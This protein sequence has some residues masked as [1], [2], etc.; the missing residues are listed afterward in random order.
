MA[1]HKT[2]KYHKFNVSKEG[3]ISGH[4]LWPICGPGGSRAIPGLFL[5]CRAMLAGNVSLETSL[6]IISGQALFGVF[7]PGHFRAVHKL[8]DTNSLAVATNS[9]TGFSVFSD[10]WAV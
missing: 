8:L 3:R 10:L 9:P 2:Q 1:G 4:N 6:K 5:F 7:G